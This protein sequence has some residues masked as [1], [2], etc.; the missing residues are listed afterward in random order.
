MIIIHDGYVYRLVSLH[1]NLNSILIKLKYKFPHHKLKRIHNFQL[2]GSLAFE[3]FKVFMRYWR[4][5]KVSEIIKTFER[6]IKPYITMN[7]ISGEVQCP[8]NDGLL[9]Q[10]MWWGRLPD[11]NQD[12][13]IYWQVG[14]WIELRAVYGRTVYVPPSYHPWQSWQDQDHWLRTCHS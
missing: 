10:R 9:F 2:M 7:Y 14:L 5:I 4:F 3:F 12:D 8:G 1:S 11:G 13:V 6:Q